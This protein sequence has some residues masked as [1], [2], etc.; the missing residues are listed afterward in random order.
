[1]GLKLDKCDIPTA[2]SV[3]A[4]VLGLDAC[5][6]TAARLRGKARADRGEYGQV[7]VLQILAQDVAPIARNSSGQRLL[8]VT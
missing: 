4:G 7:I 5:D 2:S 1:M 6:H 3:Q 8:R